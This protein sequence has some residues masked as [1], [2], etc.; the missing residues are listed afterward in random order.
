MKTI[1]SQMEGEYLSF[2]ALKKK[3]DLN[4]STSMGFTSL[5]FTIDMFIS[6]P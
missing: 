4:Q 3:I 5:P 6:F 2:F 1:M